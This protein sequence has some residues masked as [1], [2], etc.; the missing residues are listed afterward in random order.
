MIFETTPARFLQGHQLTSPDGSRAVLS[1]DVPPAPSTTPSADP[2]L[3][4]RQP[5]L[6]F[7]SGS[8]VGA[9]RQLTPSA[10]V[11]R[12]ESPASTFLDPLWQEGGRPTSSPTAAPELPAVLRPTR[13]STAEWSLPQQPA[14][15]VGDLGE[16]YRQRDMLQQ[17]MLG[18]RKAQEALTAREQKVKSRE[19]A[20]AVREQALVQL[21][22]SLRRQKEDLAKSL[23]GRHVEVQ[24]APPPPIRP[25][26]SAASQML[27]DKEEKLA[28]SMQSVEDYRNQ[29]R[30]AHKELNAREIDL[31]S[32]KAALHKQQEEL[33]AREA[34]LAARETI[35][36]DEQ[37]AVFTDVRRH[38]ERI[39][40]SGKEIERRARDVASREAA[41]E[42]IEYELQLRRIE[43]AKQEEHLQRVAQD[44][45]HRSL[46]IH[47]CI[48]ESMKL[49]YHAK[50]VER[51][52][53]R[54]HEREKEL[55]SK[56]A[57]CVPAAP[58]ALSAVSK[59]L[60]ALRG[61]L[62]AMQGRGIPVEKALFHSTSS[63]R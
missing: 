38:A 4:A 49:E 18:L 53:Q 8:S 12:A 1:P 40:T 46:E 62:D 13:R 5:E 24:V 35:V 29:L 11:R 32:M 55:W 51:E 41:A 9:T 31:E 52:M 59:S 10:A 50:V 14:A 37:D 28:H 45:D 56:A 48:D 58:P 15:T 54:L 30:R 61:E 20:A 17:A 3:A 57:A 25:M 47:H 26:E 60:F 34:A 42:S 39:Q 22:D 16:L 2:L 63:R 44:L 27:F 33:A 6:L 36:F 21:E 7:D 23:A 43:I 19:D